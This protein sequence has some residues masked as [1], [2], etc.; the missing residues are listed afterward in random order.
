MKRTIAILDTPG[1]GPL[2]GY[3]TPA[4]SR[5]VRSTGTLAEDLAGCRFVV[6]VNSNAGND[7]LVAGV[8]VLAF[9]P[10]M[11]GMA[12]AA[13]ETDIPGLA[14]RIAMML[15]GYR[16]DPGVVTRYLQWLACRQW[17]SADLADGKVLGKLLEG[18]L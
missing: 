14:G 15:A 9:G 4:T 18:K 3:V 10:S 5:A 12:G 1:I 16:P 2:S 13:L 7:A 6:T 11:Y 8:P 17:S